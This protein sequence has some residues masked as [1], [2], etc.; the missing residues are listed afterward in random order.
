[1]ELSQMISG[2]IL[3]LEQKSAIWR[4][5]PR[6]DQFISQIFLVPKKDGSQGPVVNLKPLNRLMA[7]RKFIWRAQ[8]H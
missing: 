6:P 3:E 2:K 8:E 5:N 1:M 7:K 4:V